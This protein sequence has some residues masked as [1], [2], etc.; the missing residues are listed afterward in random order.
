MAQQVTLPIKSEEVNQ[1]LITTEENIKSLGKPI[2]VLEHFIP[3]YKKG[4]LNN[5]YYI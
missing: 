2:K 4:I 1:W 3:K 5:H